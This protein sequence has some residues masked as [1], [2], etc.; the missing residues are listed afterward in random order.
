VLGLTS[1]GIGFSQSA[2]GINALAGRY[3]RPRYA[4]HANQDVVGAQ[5]VHGCF[6]VAKSNGTKVHS[7]RATRPTRA[8]ATSPEPDS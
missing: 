2:V 8:G 4:E 5:H 6:R 7:C 1:T 3:M